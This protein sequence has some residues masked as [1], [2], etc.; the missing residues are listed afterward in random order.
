MAHAGTVRRHRRTLAAAAG[1]LALLA[2]GGLLL[3]RQ[4]AARPAAR[5][6]QSPA[7][8]VPLSKPPFTVAPVH[9]RLGE[10]VA[11]R[12]PA[13][14]G[15]EWVLSFV[16]PLGERTPDLTI[17]LSIGERDPD[18]TITETLA[19]SDDRLTDHAPGFHP[20]QAPMQL[21]GGLIQPA[22]G[23][24]VGR[25]ARITA[26]FDD[27]TT[28]AAQLAPWSADPDVTIFWFDPREGAVEEV[29]ELGAFDATGAR[30]PDGTIRVSYF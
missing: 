26:V 27:V 19:I 15:A 4:Q 23:Y 12:L 21:D 1:V 14:P 7:P 24:Y 5:W 16:P 29:A 28:V 30:M 13:S 25:P 17:S 3:A 20:M 11:T 22:F 6:V 8:A 9:G 10:V 18:G 2:G